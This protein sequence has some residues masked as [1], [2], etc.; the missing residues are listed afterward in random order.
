MLDS[1]KSLLKIHISYLGVRYANGFLGIY[2]FKLVI[3]LT[4]NRAAI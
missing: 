4:L 1:Q 2:R 3:G